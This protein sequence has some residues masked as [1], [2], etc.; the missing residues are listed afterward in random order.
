MKIYFGGSIRG[1]R[2]DTR[3]YSELIK[4]C[5]KYGEVLT[6]HLGDETLTSSGEDL[7]DRLIHDRD[8][9][10]LA[11]AEVAIFEVTVPST[12]AGYEIGRAVEKP[13]AVLCL[14]RPEPGK[15]LSAMIAGNPDIELAEYTTIEEAK[16]AIDDFFEDLENY[17]NQL[18]YLA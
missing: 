1:G 15:R 12:G 4:Y 17:P 6:E 9:K 5:K 16:K 2:E 14:Y 3:F 18:F 11:D 13:M 10:W 8:L 7:D